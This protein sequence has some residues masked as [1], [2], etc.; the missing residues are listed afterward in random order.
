MTV[1]LSV[2]LAKL[3]IA[4]TEILKAAAEYRKAAGKAKTAADN[5]AANWEGEAQAAFVEE[6]SKAYGWHMQMCDIAESF[7]R[8]IRATLEKYRDG[9]QTIGEI[10]K[11]M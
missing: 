9:E 11:S 7:G 4:E 8:A 5:L 1:E 3:G 10:I 6:Q 2:E